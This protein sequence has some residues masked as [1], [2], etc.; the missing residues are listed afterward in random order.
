MALATGK[1]LLTLCCPHGSNNRCEAEQMPG[2]SHRA[3][4]SNRHQS[5]QQENSR[6][7]ETSGPTAPGRGEQ[8]MSACHGQTLCCLPLPMHS[9]HSRRILIL[10]LEPVNAMLHMGT[11]LDKQIP[12]ITTN[13]TSEDSRQQ[14]KKTKRGNK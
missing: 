5:Q 10:I 9:V 6:G 12:P 14:K 2:H 7:V 13:T 1:Y 11:H 8:G 4:H 3:A